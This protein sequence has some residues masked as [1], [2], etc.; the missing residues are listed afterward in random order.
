MEAPPRSPLFAALAP[1]ALARAF[2]PVASAFRIRDERPK[3]VAAREALLDRGFGIGR[4]AKTC[5]RLREN[6]RPAEDLSFVAT[7]GATVVA[8]LRFWQIEAG[9]R[10]S[11]LLGPLS[12]DA[13]HRSAGIGRAMVAHGLGRARAAGHASVLLVGDASYYAR[14]GFARAPVEKLVLPGPVDRDRFLGLEFVPGA[15]A[16]AQ[17]RVVGAGF[18]VERRAG[19]RLRRA[20]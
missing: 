7:V 6:R 20:A 1:P 16:G 14:F 2:R 11:L 10:A 12:V 19:E 17:G 4:F 13:R 9:D 15:L 8:T 18:I 3:D 5:E